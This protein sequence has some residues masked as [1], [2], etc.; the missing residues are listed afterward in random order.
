MTEE[1]GPKYLMAYGI[2]TAASILLDFGSLCIIVAT[3]RGATLSLAL[4]NGVYWYC[5]YRWIALAYSLKKRLPPAVAE[6]LS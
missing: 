4:L 1:L 3:V 2:C 5:L 6:N